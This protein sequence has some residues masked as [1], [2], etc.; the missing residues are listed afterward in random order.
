MISLSV[1]YA[2]S[3]H[4]IM[5]RAMSAL[6]VLIIVMSVRVLRLAQY[7]KINLRITLVSVKHALPALILRVVFVSCAQLTV[8]S[9]LR[10]G[11]TRAP[12]TSCSLNIS[13]VSLAHNKHSSLIMSAWRAA[14][15]A[16]SALRLAAPSA[17]TH[18]SWRQVCAVHVGPA[19]FSL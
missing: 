12:Q 1:R 14:V 13:L 6:H 16:I 10:R 3:V 8:S 2:L 7:V 11:A 17:L 18:L 9:V 4:I 5:K 15:I 19:L